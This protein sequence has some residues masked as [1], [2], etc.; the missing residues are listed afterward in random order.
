M[1]LLLAYFFAGVSCDGTPA[2]KTQPDTPFASTPHKVVKEMLKL[3]DTG[4]DD[5]VYDLG[6]GDGRIVIAAARDFGAKG[7]GIELDGELFKES[8]INAEKAGVSRSVRFIQEDF[9][10]TVL[11]DATVV[12]LYLL[13]EVNDLL[14]PK[15]IKELRPGARIVSHM[16]GL[17]DWEPDK[18]LNA[19]GKTLYMWFVPAHIN[20]D[21]RV[22]LQN[23]DDSKEYSLSIR[24]RYQKIGAVLTD[25][26]N[27]YEFTHTALYG[28]EIN[29]YVSYAY[30]GKVAVVS[31]EG[32]VR[33]DVMEGKAFIK[34]ADKTT[35]D[36]YRWTARRY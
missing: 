13:P 25:S 18:I 7:V 10:E 14:M 28:N 3:A 35:A 23:K 27:R 24:Q 15:L 5:V 17:G 32:V 1:L 11:N 31:L 26:K 16:W 9:F 8:K 12:T 20:G 4:K 2:K 21:W 6:S 30:E 19:Y 33:G 34:E 22:T 29:L 36:E